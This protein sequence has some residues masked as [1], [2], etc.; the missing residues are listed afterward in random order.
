ML[1]KCH[2]LHTSIDFIDTLHVDSVDMFTLDDVL[3]TRTWWGCWWWGTLEL[4]DDDTGD[5]LETETVLELELG[6]GIIVCLLIPASLLS[7]TLSWASLI[8]MVVLDLEL[9]R[10]ARNFLSNI[11]I[12]FSA[13]EHLYLMKISESCLNHTFYGRFLI[14]YSH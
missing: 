4:E 2:H 10:G 11:S 6:V 3:R 9:D 1:T 12:S 8:T 5:T 13:I 14:I 7:L